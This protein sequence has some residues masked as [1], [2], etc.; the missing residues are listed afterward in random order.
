MDPASITLASI[1]AF[2]KLLDGIKK[3]YSGYKL[4]ASFGEDFDRAQRRFYILQIRLEKDFA[5]KLSWLRD[6]ERTCVVNETSDLSKAIVN[7][8]VLID[9][10]NTACT[11]LMKKYHDRG[12]TAKY[13]WRPEVT[14]S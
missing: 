13:N 6:D 14:V 7:Q 9:Q 11:N 10:C 12:K 5:T 8:L 2:A 1:G 3:A 4:T